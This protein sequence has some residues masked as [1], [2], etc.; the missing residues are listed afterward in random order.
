[1]ATPIGFAD[2]NDCDLRCLIDRLSRRRPLIS[3]FDNIGPP[4]SDQR[5]GGPQAQRTTTP[6]PDSNYLSILL[7]VFLVIGVIVLVLVV[8]MLHR[9]ISLLLKKRLRRGNNDSGS[10]QQTEHNESSRRIDDSPPS[11]RQMMGS[12]E[13]GDMPPS[14]YEIVKGKVNLGFLPEESSI[15][16]VMSSEGSTQVVEGP[17]S[18]FSNAAADLPNSVSSADKDSSEKEESLAGDK[19]HPVDANNSIKEEQK[20]FDIE[21]EIDAL[22]VPT[23]FSSSPVLPTRSSRHSNIKMLKVIPHLASKRNDRNVTDIENFGTTS[24]DDNSSTHGSSV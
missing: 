22:S 21:Q 23:V 14:Y 19:L 18:N 8:F 10:G 15:E 9:F 13:N 5:D 4:G 2:E 16:N 1:M 24:N 11:Y 20:K 6:A 12:V 17:G 3:P 7:P